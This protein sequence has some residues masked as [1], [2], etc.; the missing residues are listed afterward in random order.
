LHHASV[1]RFVNP[2]QK[3][4]LAGLQGSEHVVDI[5]SLFYSAVKAKKDK[6]LFLL[7]T[8][9]AFDSIDHDWITHVL[10]KTGFPLWFR[11]FVKGSLSSVKVSPFFGGSLTDWID[12]KRGVKQPLS[13]LLF[14]IAYHPLLDYISRTPGVR[15][16][17]FADDLALFSDSVETISP[18]LSL[19]SRFSD[20]SGLGINKD[21]SVAIPTAGPSRWPFI[22]LALLSCPWPDLP[23]AESGA[24]L[25]ITVG[26]NVDL[27]KLWS[28]PMAKAEA[29]LRSNK[30]VITSLSV[31]S[32]MLYMNVF[33][34]SLFSYVALFFVLPTPLWKQ[35]RG[36]IQRF[37][38]FHGGS[39]SGY[40]LVC[41]KSLF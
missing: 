19:I 29:R 31:S 24:H 25:G 6:L 39:Y 21:K 15:S 32:R 38:P 10:V 4:F 40:T 17:A 18:A 8:A 22:R 5:N 23:L 1:T 2:S 35:I 30:H 28:G 36:L 41:A 33:I 14:I 26:R 34:I 9:K 27:K 12:I 7:D 20:V 16:F 3:G 11:N 13:P 37:F